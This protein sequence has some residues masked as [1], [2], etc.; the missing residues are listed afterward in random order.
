MNTIEIYC[1]ANKRVRDGQSV[2]VCAHIIKEDNSYEEDVY[3]LELEGNG[4]RLELAALINALLDVEGQDRLKSDTHIMLYVHNEFI[5]KTLLKWEDYKAK[6]K[7]LPYLEETS[8]KEAWQEIGQLLEQCGSFK[9]YGLEKKY[10]EES[11]EE[12]VKHMAHLNRLVCN[13][14]NECLRSE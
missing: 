7:Q 5:L 12:A 9:I 3:T 2:S 14:V 6:G 11:S 13:K 4:I 8:S 10:R 1:K